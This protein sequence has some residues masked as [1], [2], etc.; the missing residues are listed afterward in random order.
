MTD[1]E[2][3]TVRAYNNPTR[4]ARTEAGAVLR[5]TTDD[6]AVIEQLDKAFTA[7]MML[8]IDASVT[9]ELPKAGG[10]GQT[11]ERPDA[12]QL[13]AGYRAG[14]I[15]KET[16]LEIRAQAVEQVSV[17][18]DTVAEQAATRFIKT[19]YEAI[20]LDLGKIQTDY[21]FKTGA[22]MILYTFISIAAAI[23]V[24]LMAAYTAAAGARD[25][26]QRVYG[27]ILDFSG[28]E[29]NKF[30]AASLITRSTNDIQQI[31]IATVMLLRMVLYAPVVGVGGAIKVV[32]TGMGMGWIVVVAIVILLAVVMGLMAVTMPKFKMLQTLLDKLNLVGREILTG[33]PVIRAFGRETHEERRFDKANRALIKTQL[34]TGRAMSLMMPLM[35]FHMNLIT[36][37]IVWFGAKGVDAG[38]LQV[39]DMMAFITYTIMIVMS[40]MMLSI[41]SIMLPRANVAAERINEVLSTPLTILD[42]P[43]AASVRDRNPIGNITF[44]DVS[45]RFPD[46]EEYVLANISFEARSGETTAIIGSTGSGKSTLINLIP[47]LFDVTDGSIA[48]DGTDIRDMSQHSLRALIGLV[49]QTGVLFH[50]TV[51]SNLKFGDAHMSDDEMRRAAEIA[52]AAEFIDKKEGGYESPISQGG[53]NVSGGQKQ[54]L[55]IARAIAKRPKILIFDDS[56]SALDY[57]TDAALRRALNDRIKDMTVIIVAQRIST[58]LRADKIIVLDEGEIR[59]IGTHGE[60]MKTCEVYREIARSQ[61]SETELGA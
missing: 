18:G 10:D 20:G 38:D 16:M 25:L 47:R 61:L 21:M 54:R 3:A 60:L 23:L 17:M 29:M 42:K 40:F 51:A 33:L 43:D 46:A 59:G 19:E 2:I 9:P 4:E 48:I 55:S 30:T 12:A 50:G 32:G 27:R 15:T 39:G 1:G 26:R 34:F 53:D 13:I 22:L 41:I 37:A 44:R 28:S 31:Q 35:V 57:K 36:V 11:A 14:A 52:Q 8:L 7:P 49:P 24:C 56:F 58:I 6:G 5:R 45:F